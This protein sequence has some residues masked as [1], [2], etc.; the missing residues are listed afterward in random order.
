MGLQ[1]RERG[2]GEMETRLAREGG[3][4]SCRALWPGDRQLKF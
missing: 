4:R 1:H 3:V 2:R